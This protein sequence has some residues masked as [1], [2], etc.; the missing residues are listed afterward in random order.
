LDNILSEKRG[1]SNSK[2]KIFV[3]ND[4]FDV[5]NDSHIVLRNTSSNIFRYSNYNKSFED[6][7]NST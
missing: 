3:N 6:Q 1:R 2:D 7:K 5:D 4:S